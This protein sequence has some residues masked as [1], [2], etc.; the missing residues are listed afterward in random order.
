MLHVALAVVAA[1][2]GHA[3]CSAHARAA[4]SHAKRVVFTFTPLGKAT[5]ALVLTVGVESLASSRQNLVAVGLV[6]DVPHDLVFGG[7][8][9]VMQCHSELHHAQA[10]PKMAALFGHDIHNELAQLIADLLQFLGLEFGPEVRRKFN[11]REEGASG[12]SIH[13]GEIQGWRD[14]TNL[15]P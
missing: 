4:V 7:V 6:S 3:E 10:G 2:D 5:D 9:D 14:V 1:A 8:E 13:G 15:T 12:V 11:L